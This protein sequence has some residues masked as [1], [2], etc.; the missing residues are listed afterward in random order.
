MFQKEP[1]EM[2]ESKLM[3]LRFLRRIYMS[4]MVQVQEYRG[5]IKIK[6]KI[7]QWCWSFGCIIFDVRRRGSFG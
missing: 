3:V 6:N 2:K 1:L 4:K 5:L 7:V